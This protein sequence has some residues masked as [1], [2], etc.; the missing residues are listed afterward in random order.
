MK[1]N[2]IVSTLSHVRW[3]EDLATIPLPRTFRFSKV[4]PSA[5]PHVPHQSASDTTVR[6]REGESSSS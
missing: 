4:L 2:E 5:L 6:L 3:L 1:M